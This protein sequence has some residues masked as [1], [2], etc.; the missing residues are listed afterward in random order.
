M[1]ESMKKLEPETNSNSE[2]KWL[3]HK[4]RYKTNLKAFYLQW[5]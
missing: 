3:L 5:I 1:L 4:L 2:N